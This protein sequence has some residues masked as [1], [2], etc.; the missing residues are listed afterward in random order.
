MK[1][2]ILLAIVFYSLKS[3]PQTANDFSKLKW[4]VGEWRRTN[5]TAGTSGSEKWVFI[6]P[7]ELQGWGITMKGSDTSFMEKTKLLIK[8]DHIYYAADVPGNNETIYFKLVSINENEFSC[9]NATHDFP[10]KITYTRDGDFLKAT[11]SG[12][13]KFIDYFFE[14]TR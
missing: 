5:A 7:G 11:I 1:K 3:Y 9:E 6:S 8:Q 4:L 2:F 10:K 14:K 12:N 13:G